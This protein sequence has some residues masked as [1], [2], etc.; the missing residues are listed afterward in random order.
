MHFN[1]NKLIGGTSDEL[2]FNP[3]FNGYCT[4][5]NDNESIIAPEGGFNPYFNG[6]CTSI[7]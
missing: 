7:F 6:Y 2:S 4:S 1:V 5:I 3:Y